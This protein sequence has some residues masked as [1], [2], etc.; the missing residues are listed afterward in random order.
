MR[1][2]LY[3]PALWVSLWCLRLAYWARGRWWSDARATR[4][5]MYLRREVLRAPRRKT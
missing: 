1:R 2:W 4:A 5:Q 3:E